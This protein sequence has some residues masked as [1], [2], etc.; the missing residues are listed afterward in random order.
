MR[1]NPRQRSLHALFKVGHGRG[2]E[3]SRKNI[4]QLELSYAARLPPLAPSL[5]VDS[6]SPLLLPQTYIDVMHVSRD[7]TTRMFSLAASREEEEAKAAKAKA[8]AEG[9]VEGGGGALEAGGAKAASQS[10][11]TGLTDAEAS[12]VGEAAAQAL[13]VSMIHTV[14]TLFPG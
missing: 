2:N 13:L 5:T 7:E 12:Q 14:H 8:E 6:P 4:I 9:A 10:G 1:V 11:M 3:A